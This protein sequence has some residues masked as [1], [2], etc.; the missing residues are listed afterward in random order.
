MTKIDA[1]QLPIEE[2]ELPEE[3]LEPTWS[4]ELS[5]KLYKLIDTGDLQSAKFQL[6]LQALVEEYD[7]EVLAELLYLLCHLRF[8][9]GEAKRHWQGVAE[10]R[11][12]M[13]E[14]M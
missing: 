3:Q 9:P 11:R 10:H 12:H 2:S 14:S 13:A 7:D 4:T 5:Q 8:E 6:G 1:R